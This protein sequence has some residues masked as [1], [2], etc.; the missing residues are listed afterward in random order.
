MHIRLGLDLDGEHGWHPGAQLASVTLGPLGF[1]TVLETQLGLLLPE[2]SQAERTVQYR[3]CLVVSGLEKRFFAETFKVD[4]LGT[5]ATLLEWRDRWHIH[6]WDG[7]GLPTNVRRLKDLQDVE[8]HAATTV[9]SSVGQRLAA[10]LGAMRQRRPAIDAI[11]L[12]DPLKSFP[13]RWRDVLALL[14]M[15]EVPPSRA[16]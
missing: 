3:H 4:E 6:G 13:R 10:V 11:E 12:L 2:V 16:G 9:A 14:P 15:K 8:G 1:L 5:A 7:T